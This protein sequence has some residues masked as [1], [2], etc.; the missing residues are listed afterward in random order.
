MSTHETACMSPADGAS[1]LAN[2]TFSHL[3]PLHL[4]QNRDFSSMDTSNT[5][6]DV[7]TKATIGRDL[8]SEAYE[9]MPIDEFGRNVLG[10][11]GWTEGK[12]VGRTQS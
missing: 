10:K 1:D 9:R 4:Y 3:F 12:G 11:L 6:Y 8:D 7:A 2:P 5:T